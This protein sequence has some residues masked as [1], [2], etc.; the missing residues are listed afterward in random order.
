MSFRSASPIA[1]GSFKIGRNEG[2]KYA[3]GYELPSEEA[4]IALVRAAVA[5]GIRH[6]DTAP[7]YGLAER[8]VGLALAGLAEPVSVSTKVGERFEA[9]R[10]S[11]DFSASGTRSS[12]ARSVGLLG[13]SRLDL[14]LVHSNGDD[15]RILREEGVTAALRRLREEGTV[16]A[17]GFSAKTLAGA[18][19]ALDAGY[20]S[21]MLEYHPLDPGLRPAFERAAEL[22]RSVLVKKAL[23]SG[24]L[25]ASES[26]PFAL[27][28]PA[29]TSVVV[30]SLRADHLAECVSLAHGKAGPVG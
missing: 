23:A 27:A 5:L 3:E 7:A 20:D 11:Y 21:L 28:A 30:G 13:R 4:A 14:V 9:G 26:I 12:V 19:A 2:I 6:V 18:L 10:S 29:V 15:E 17:I 24:R 1:F 16:A 22:G 25:P 8:R